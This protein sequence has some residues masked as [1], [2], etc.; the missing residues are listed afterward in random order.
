V[1]RVLSVLLCEA[2]RDLLVIFWAEEV[3]EEESV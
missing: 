1:A 2:I 3:R